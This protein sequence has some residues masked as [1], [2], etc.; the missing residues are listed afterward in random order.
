MLRTVRELVLLE[1]PEQF[2]PEQV[3]QLDVYYMG[4]QL[5]QPVVDSCYDDRDVDEVRVMQDNTLLTRLI[6]KNGE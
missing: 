3:Q 4:R 1:L 5:L 6:S 2:E